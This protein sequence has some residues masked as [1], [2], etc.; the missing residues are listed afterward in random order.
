MKST[1][2]FS[3]SYNKHPW[4]ILTLKLLQNTVGRSA[5]CIWLFEEPCDD[6]RK[7]HI[8]SLRWVNCG[9]RG[10]QFT[11][12]FFFPHNWA[13]SSAPG[14]MGHRET[15]SFL[16]TM[17]SKH[18]FRVYIPFH[19]FFV[20]DLT[21]H[22][23]TRHILLKCIHCIPKLLTQPRLRQF[24]E[25]TMQPIMYRFVLVLHKITACSNMSKSEEI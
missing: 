13:N 10:L 25:I 7:P 8:L 21:G 20:T 12:L 16:F 15:C 18:M 22:E 9:H 11:I 6:S 19:V 1:H 2:S 17:Q 5:N 3:E 23:A 14:R 24:K 4:I